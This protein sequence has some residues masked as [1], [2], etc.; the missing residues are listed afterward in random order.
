MSASAIQTE[1]LFGVPFPGGVDTHWERENRVVW[2]ARDHVNEE[3]ELVYEVTWISE[4][5]VWRRFLRS[6]RNVRTR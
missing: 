3:C 1:A 5:G 6:Q 4:L 2:N